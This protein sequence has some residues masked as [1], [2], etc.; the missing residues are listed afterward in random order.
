MA[1]SSIE[2]SIKRRRVWWIFREYELR[3]GDESGLYVTPADWF[4]L[5]LP[6]ENANEPQRYGYISRSG[7]IYPQYT[8][9][10]NGNPLSSEHM[11]FAQDTWNSRRPPCDDDQYTYRRVLLDA[12]GH[13]IRFCN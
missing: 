2:L 8:D 6:R 1:R 11:R 10:L 12:N 7:T 5:K 4:N 3:W 9:G 13:F